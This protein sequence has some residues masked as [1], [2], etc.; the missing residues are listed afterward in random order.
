MS[1]VPL[2]PAAAREEFTR[3]AVEAAHVAGRVL[4]EQVRTGFRIEHK[5]AVNLVT[6]ADRL[7]E[8]AIIDVIRRSYPTHHILAEERG[9]ESGSESPYRWIIDPL[10]GTTNFA[11]GFPAYCVSI[12]LE[13]QGQIIMGVVWT[14]LARN[15]SSPRRNRA[16]R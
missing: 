5:D 12:A 4:N 2:P 10:D 6:D 9:L 13:Y 3:R 8:Q 7:A 14:R 15:C 1:T 11:H 16:R